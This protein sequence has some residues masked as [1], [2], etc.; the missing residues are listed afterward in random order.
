MPFLS[1]KIPEAKTAM[2]Q[3]WLI[4]HSFYLE[5]RCDYLFKLVTKEGSI[6]L[7]LFRMY[8]ISAI[9]SLG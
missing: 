1:N 4:M 6:R 5:M 2:L 3:N 9:A 7:G 8:F